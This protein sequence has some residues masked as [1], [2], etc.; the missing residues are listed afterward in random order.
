MS[1]LQSI[2]EIGSRHWF[3]LRST[4]FLSVNF[5]EISHILGYW[6]A[7]PARGG[8]RGSNDSRCSNNVTAVS[9]ILRL[10]LLSCISWTY[11]LRVPLYDSRASGADN[12]N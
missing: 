6:V 8:F 9:F 2:C 7:D 12:L 11:L 4:C 10:N 3:F 5:C 1:A